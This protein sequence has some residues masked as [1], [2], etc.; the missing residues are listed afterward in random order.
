[1]TRRICETH[2]V[3]LVEIKEG[4]K[5]R[6]G[7]WCPTGHAGEEWAVVDENN[8]LVLRATRRGPIAR[9]AS[10]PIPVLLSG[11]ACCCA[12]CGHT[13]LSRCECLHAQAIGPEAHAMAQ[14]EGV[15]ASDCKPPSKCAACDAKN[16]WMPRSGSRTA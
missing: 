2:N 12:R 3:T 1:M 10:V 7:L 15:H 16:W 8:R 5:A 6:S 4:Q 9:G 14:H 13:W 11:W